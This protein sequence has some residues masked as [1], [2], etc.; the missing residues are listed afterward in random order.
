LESALAARNAEAIDA[1]R[2]WLKESR[3]EDVQLA[4]LAAQASIP[5]DPSQQA[6][7]TGIGQRVEGS[8]EK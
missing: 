3:L 1:I 5:G 7:Q 4:R 2:D 6:D 8:S